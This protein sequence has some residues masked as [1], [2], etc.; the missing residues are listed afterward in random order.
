MYHFL[1]RSLVPEAL[2]APPERIDVSRPSAILAV[3]SLGRLESHSMEIEK[4]IEAG[5]WG[6]NA[7]K[8]AWHKDRMLFIANGTIIAGFDLN[9]LSEG[10]VVETDS[11]ITVNL[12]KPMLLVSRLDNVKSRVYDRDVGALNSAD[13]HLESKTRAKAE[14]TL[15]TAACEAEI[16]QKAGEDGRQV[17]EN[18]LE[19]VFAAADIDMTVNVTFEEGKC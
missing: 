18:L 19:Q 8:E 15:R 11:I 12:G 7:F 13:P 9:T 6:G 16:L 3:R 17:V 5:T 1:D 4:I 14:A 10:S 2:A